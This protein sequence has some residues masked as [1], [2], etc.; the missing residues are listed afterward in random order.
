MKYQ[1]IDTKDMDAEEAFQLLENLGSADDPIKFRGKEMTPNDLYY[2]DGV[3]ECSRR[4]EP[5]L[6]PGQIR[7]GF[8]GDIPRGQDKGVG[9]GWRPNSTLKQMVED[10]IRLKER[11]RH[12]PDGYDSMDTRE[13]REACERKLFQWLGSIRSCPRKN[14]TDFAGILG[15]EKD[16]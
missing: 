12:Q 9:F 15:V 3:G 1:G 13:L 6:R 10:R 14:L 5:C 16:E 11:D 7:I 2:E 4:L 8:Y